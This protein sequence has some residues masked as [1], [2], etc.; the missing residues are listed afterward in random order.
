[1]PPVRQR[2][3]SIDTAWLRM[4]TPENL[5]VITG[6]MTFD[7]T[8]TRQVLRELLAERFLRFPR[9]RT[10]PRTD[11]LG[12]WWEEDPFFDLDRHI[13]ELSLPEPGGEREL[14]ALVSDLS[15]TPLPTNKPLWEYHLVQRAGGKTALINRIHHAYAD[16]IAMIR[17]ILSMTDKLAVVQGD[18]PN[19]GRSRKSRQKP[20]TPLARLYEPARDLARGS[21]RATQ[22]LWTGGLELAMDPGQASDWAMHGLGMASELA[23]V[24]LMSDDPIT[25]L[26]KPLGG[27]KQVAWA[28]PLPLTEVK[29]LGKALGCT[30]NDVLLS[31]AAGTLGNYLRGQ[32]HNIDGLGI[33]ASVPVN[34]RPPD[35]ELKLGNHFGLVF[36]ELPVGITN[37]IDRIDAVHQDMR[38]LKGSYQPLVSLGL[39]AALGLA[40][41]AVQS[42]ALDM[43]SSKASTVMSNVPGPREPLYLAGHELV[44]QMFW[45]PQTGKVGVGVS[46]LSYNGRVHFGIIADSELVDDPWEL[47]RGFNKEFEKL[48]MLALIGPW[49]KNK[50]AKAKAPAK[51]KPGKNKSS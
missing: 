26:K 1:M 19:K 23:K 24:T 22:K 10:I 28:D 45:V 47:T 43:L 13:H 32:G 41:S 40:P 30:V 42:A 49:E 37:P 7:T 17:V 46:I 14:A 18:L 31:C 15:S 11:V 39:L 20:N 27:R 33:R 34:M 38:E 2:M 48:M 21:L 4:D 3:S 16:G 50:D 36:L 35:Q 29:A 6:I 25:C 8:L 51:R 44:D 5:M 9:F 12:A